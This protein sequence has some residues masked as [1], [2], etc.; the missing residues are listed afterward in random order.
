VFID[1]ITISQNHA[2]SDLTIAKELTA[3]RVLSL[4]ADGSIDWITDKY[5][6]HQGSYDTRIMLRCVA[7]TVAVSGNVGAWN[8][9]DNVFG[10]SFIDV[11]LKVNQI[12][13]GFGIPPFT[14]GETYLRRKG[15]DD[16]RHELVWTGAT[17]SRLDLTQNFETA[18]PENASLYI[19]YLSGL[20]PTR[21]R[22]TVQGNAD[23]IETV[24]SGEKSKFRTA[25]IYNKAEEF[26]KRK[27]KY[28]QETYYQN[29]LE[30]LEEN[31]VI[32][33]ELRLRQRFL[34][35]QRLRY[36]GDIMRNP[37]E[38]ELIF[39]QQL[40]KAIRP[41]KVSSL[42]DL[43]QPALSYYLT[44]EKGL[45]FT[46]KRSRSSAYQHRKE[47]LD[48]MGIDISNPHGSKVNDLPLQNR[49]IDVVPAQKPNGYYLPQIA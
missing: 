7:N 23:T 9:P 22:T 33:Y 16:K 39:K 47:I 49:V 48:V 34:T 46:Q 8:R 26:K 35:Q 29:L 21:L 25:L 42:N 43:S 1:W 18:S 20:K 6:Q 4:D 13:A 32:R 17:I 40:N 2:D 37:N 14:C 30:Y 15:F 12:L 31:G 45:L 28:L 27:A 44:W 36:L 19:N 38:L 24:Y 41:V 10:Y 11:I 3:G 5:Y